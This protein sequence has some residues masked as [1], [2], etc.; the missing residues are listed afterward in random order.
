MPSRGR[1]AL[2]AIA[3]AALFL[4]PLLPEA[5]GKRRLV[6]RDAQITHWPWRRVATASLAQGE[7]PFVNA[8]AS[9]GQ[10]MLA[11]PNAVLLY[12]TF[13]LEKVLPPSAAFNWH[14][15]L[16]VLW[17]FFGAR[18]LARRMGLSEGPALFTG[19]T[20]AF[21]GMLL[22]YGSAFMNSSAAASWLPWCAAATLDLA[23]ARHLRAIL[24]SSAAAGLGLGLQLLAGEPALSLL[25]LAFIMYLALAEA[26]AG[27]V[28]LDRTRS[29]RALLLGGPLAG[30]LALGLAAPLLFP[31]WKVF[32]YTYRGLHLYSEKAFGAAPFTPARAIEWLLPRF[33][34]DPGLMGGGAGWLSPGSQGNFVYIW[35]LTFGVI[36]LVILLVASVRRD[37]WHR[38]TFT[39]A[40]AGLVTLLFS[41]GLTLP[42]YRLLYSVESLRRLRYPIKFYLLTTLCVALLAGFAAESLRHRVVRR[43]RREAAVLAAVLALFVAAWIAAGEGGLLEARVQPILDQM[44]SPPSGFLPAFRT[45]VRGDALL[46]SA[47]TLFVGLLVLTRRR[48]RG[49]GQILGISTLLFALVWALPLFVSA[50]DKELARPPALLQALRGGGRLHVSR[51]LPRVDVPALEKASDHPVKLPRVAQASRVFAE[52]LIPLSASRYGVRY[53]FEN[54]PDGSYGYFNRLAGEVFDASTP[55]EKSRLLRAYGGRWILSDESVTYPLAHPVTGFSVAGTRL[56]LQ[57]LPNPVAEVRWAG[58]AHGRRSLSGALELVRSERF[59]PGSEVVLPARSDS[60]PSGENRPAS[61][62]I[63]SLRADRASALV[64]ASAPGHLLFSRTYFPVWKA[65][66]DGASTPVRVANARELA[67]AVPRGRHRV[68]LWYDREPFHRGVFLQAAALLLVALAL[69]PLRKTGPLAPRQTAD[70]G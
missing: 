67:V 69:L 63:E 31:L 47:A 29:L 56:L 12:P 48:P 65:S 33:G 64:T 62:T 57:E 61:V 54:D 9:G 20:F 8:F 41:V 25:T 15:F 45:A 19:V 44:A 24:R 32:P 4:L 11:N 7:V 42:F 6:F 27:K 36:P 39:L 30:L 10:P 17:A 14:Y 59:D 38:K 35:C 22:S 43:A 28:A 53:L 34:G 1:A 37:F 52:Q 68:E 21:S 2:G 50:S 49:L 3:V 66:L 58:R 13:L 60:G 5:L 26:L 18:L 46:G 16:H 55:P 51:E 40:A 70:R 23:R